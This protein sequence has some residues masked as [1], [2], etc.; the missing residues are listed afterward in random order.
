MLA[1]KG[2]KA[3]GEFDAH[4]LSDGRFTAEHVSVR[5]VRDA[6]RDFAHVSHPLGDD[7]V[8]LDALGKLNVLDLAAD[9]RNLLC[10]AVAL[11]VLDRLNGDVRSIDG[12]DVSGAGPGAEER[13][14]AGA[15]ADVK[16]SR[17]LEEFRVGK[18]E[19][20]VRLGPRRV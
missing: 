6:W 5:F 10:A 4:S 12:V 7:D 14:N 19:E 20:R 3:Q 1:N 11:D 13:E 9:D 2:P 16:D 17:T 8:D 15:A 18:N